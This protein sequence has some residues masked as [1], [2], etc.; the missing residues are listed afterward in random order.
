[1]PFRRDAAL[2]AA[3]VGIAAST[4]RAAAELVEHPWL[5]V[6]RLSPEL[7]QA[8]AH[9]DVGGF[10]AEVYPASDKPRPITFWRPTPWTS[11]R[12]PS[13]SIAGLRTN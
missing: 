5:R 12:K 6:R 10:Y 3:L 8:L 11:C 4:R 13:G 7:S 2:S 1:M 9:E